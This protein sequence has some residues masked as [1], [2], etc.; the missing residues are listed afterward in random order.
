M[1]CFNHP[2]QTAVAQCVDCGKGLCPECAYIERLCID[3]DYFGI[4]V[5]KRHCS[6][7]N[8]VGRQYVV[9]YV[10]RF[11]ICSVCSDRI[12]YRPFHN[13]MEHL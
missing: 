10:L 6:I 11:Q 5:R 9:A 7:Q 8:G 1:N 3:V 2:T 4:P 13:R 12:L